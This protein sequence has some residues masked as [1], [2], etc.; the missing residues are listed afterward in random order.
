MASTLVTADGRE[1]EA[2]VLALATGFQTLEM[3]GPMEITG[4]SGATLR[5]TWGEEEAR[6][7]LGM[8]VPDFPNFF[9]LFGPN[10]NTGHG[11]SAFLTTEM[12][13]RYVMQLVAAMVERGV[14]SVECR[15]EVH[16]AYDAEL[17]EALAG[18]V[19]THHKAHGYYRNKN[20]R[21]IGSSPWEYLTYWQRTR[22]PSSRTTCCRG[23]PVRGQ[24]I[25]SGP[26]TSPATN[27][28][29]NGSSEEKTWSTGPASTT[30]PFQSSE[31]WSLT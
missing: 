1:V 17:Q 13:V 10:T 31:M 15:P 29:T 24:S 18:T 28:C 9:I 11:G 23:V 2:D 7:Y 26:A 3:L 12:Q 5:E 4:R 21:I 22:E 27:C 25:A 20:D 30:E 19:Y 6:A 8:A 14:D 16:D